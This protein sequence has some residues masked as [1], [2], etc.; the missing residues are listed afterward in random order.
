MALVWQA[1]H[2]TIPPHHQTTTTTGQL[3]L[4]HSHL[5]VVKGQTVREA[6]GLL[7]QLVAALVPLPCRQLHSWP[8]SEGSLRGG[9][10]SRVWVRGK[11]QESLAHKPQDL[12][13]AFQPAAMRNEKRHKIATFQT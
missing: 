4:F 1:L 9:R 12:F 6:P 5:L 13:L 10:E 3:W 11:P 8:A 7:L 2:C